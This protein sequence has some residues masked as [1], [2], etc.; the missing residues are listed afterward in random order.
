MVNWRL[1]KGGEF[2]I[3]ETLPEEIFTPEDFNMDQRLI[4]KSA[5]EFYIKELLP[6][7]EDIEAFSR[8]LTRSMLIKMGELGFIGADIPESYGGTELDKVSS[9]LITEH[10]S[11][12]VLGFGI[13]FAVQTGI[14]SLPIVLFGTRDQKE[15][16]LPGLARCDLV[17]AYALT[18][19]EHGSDALSADTTALMSDDGEY[20]LLNGQKQFITNAGFADLFITYG[21]LDGDKFTAFIV[22]RDWEGVSLGEEEEKMGMHGSSTRAVFFK[23]VRVPKK[24]LLGEIGRGHVVALN[25]LNIGRYKLGATTLGNSKTLISEAIRHARGRVQ[26]GRPICEFGLIKHKLAE[27]IIRTYVNECMLYRTAGLLDLALKDIE[28][29]LEDAGLRTGEAISRY[30][31]ECSINKVYGSELLDFVAD[32]CV[33][34]MGGYGFIR[35]YPAEGIYRD[36]RINRIWEGTNEINRLLIVDMLMRADMKGELPL[37]KAI[38]KATD[39]PLTFGPDMAEEENMLEKEKKMVSMAKKIGLIALGAAVEKY[40]TNLTDK[41]EIIALISDIII[42]IFAMESALLRTLKIIEK[43]GEE[44]AEIQAAITSVYI[45]DTFPKVGLMAKQVF[46]AISEGEE[47]KTNLMSL[48]RLAKYTPVNSITLR[49]KI[50]ESSIPAARYHLTK[51]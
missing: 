28:L 11:A 42:E 4:G 44:Q 36:A 13:T 24:N 16:Y 49:R 50:A 9:A 35:D 45:N 30:A 48:E 31:L 39:E 32:E 7:K 51:L 6:Y 12:G 27:M 14:G 33:Q 22:E 38:K 37:I 23:D 19:P 3:T 40:M 41:Q 1:F 26:F 18:E 15:R 43:E 29:T 21:Q 8:D 25:T 10:I 46:A 5:E 47:L 20:Y 2:L 17:G 34:I